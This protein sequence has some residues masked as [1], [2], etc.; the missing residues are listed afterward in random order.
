MGK[1]QVIDELRAECKMITIRNLPI[2]VEFTDGGKIIR[3]KEDY[4]VYTAHQNLVDEFNTTKWEDL[5][6]T[7]IFIGIAIGFGLS[8]SEAITMALNFM[9][10][11]R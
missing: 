3:V 2:G 9:P 11:K 5:T 7:Q 4:K 10:K 1:F 8:H 6:M